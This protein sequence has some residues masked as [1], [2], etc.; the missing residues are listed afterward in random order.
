MKALKH[1]I[2]VSFLLTN[3]LAFAQQETYDVVTY[4]IPKGWQKQQVNGGVQL[5]VTD[6]KTGG[7]AIAIITQSMASTGSADG[8][9]KS[10]WKTLL[11]NT[12]N[13]I[14]EPAME[15]PVQDN[16]W[17]ILSGQGNYVDRN[18]K[19]LAS[20]LTATGNNQTAAVVLMTNTQQ[21]QND[22][23]A[24]MN[25]LSLQ[26]LEQEPAPVINPQPSSAPGKNS[27]VGLWH[28]YLNETSGY[29]NN[30]PQ[31]TAGYFRKEYTFNANGT[32]E[33]RL[34]N[35]S[36]Y[37]KDIQFAYESGTWV[38]NGS[39]LTLTPS[40]GRSEWWS[41]APSNRTT[42]WGKL[43]K[44]G[45]YKLEKQE[46]LFNIEYF[47]GS[48]DYTIVLKTTKPTQRDG[49]NFNASGEP[50]EFRYTFRKELG[51]LIDNPP[52]FKVGK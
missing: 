51:S 3:I 52:G 34:K 32:Y 15:T 28:S 5:F 38:V 19:G 44:P 36:V 33:Y 11:V 10:Q 7:Y 20:L 37:M 22:L 41:K 21:Y 6:T 24:F 16:G 48:Q 49:G 27:I 42:E 13:S 50:Y 35:W 43:V 45:E 29:L 2:L 14:T 23:L 9:F 47:S 18:I 40:A 8:D 30:W 26:K 46:Y 17:E 31:Y 39:K 25:S 12:V 4:T 1:I